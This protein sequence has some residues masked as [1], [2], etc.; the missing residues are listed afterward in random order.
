MTRLLS[1]S[2]FY[3]YVPWH[4]LNLAACFCT[5]CLSKFPPLKTDAISSQIKHRVTWVVSNALCLPCVSGLGWAT[6]WD[7]GAAMIMTCLEKILPLKDVCNVFHAF[8]THIKQACRFF[9]ALL[10]K[11]HTLCTPEPW[12]WWIWNRIQCYLWEPNGTN[13]EILFH[14]EKL[15]IF[16]DSN[17]SMHP[18][19]T[20]SKEKKSLSDSLHELN[21]CVI[22]S[23]T[24]AFLMN[25]VKFIN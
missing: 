3:L 22:I 18:G 9:Y 11:R 7:T 20:L 15:R 24:W 21:K 12:K 8:L 23:F 5:Q 2:L 6:L 14:W 25:K 16:K 1:V 10:L 13:Q 17:N 19:N 4:A